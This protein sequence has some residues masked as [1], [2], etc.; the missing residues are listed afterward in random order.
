MIDANAVTWTK[1]DVQKVYDGKPL[2]AFA[3]RATDKHG[4]EL[5]VEYSIDGET[6]TFDPAEISLTHFGSQKVL[7]RATGSNYTAGQYATSS[8]KIA[9]NKRPV[10]LTS[11]SANKVYDGKPL[12]NDTVTSTPLGVGVGFLDGEGVTCNVTGSQTNVGESDNEF[13]YTF[14]EGSS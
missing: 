11:A 8:E 7:L 10:T 9:I 13:T 14:N 5:N 12:T 6:W 1:Q 4:N 3:A 2:S